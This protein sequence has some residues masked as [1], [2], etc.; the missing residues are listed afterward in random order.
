MR[1]KSLRF[2]KSVREPLII[3]RQ[4]PASPVIIGEVF[5]GVVNKGSFTRFGEIDL[6]VLIEGDVY[7]IV[8]QRE[9]KEVKKTDEIIRLKFNS[10]LELDS[11]ALLRTT[12]G[13]LI[14]VTTQAHRGR[15]RI[16]CTETLPG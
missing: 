13:R 1:P 3:R 8:L 4:N 2:I 10:G 9:N 16:L 6:S 12:K 11:D 15:Q 5:K 14:V 7:L